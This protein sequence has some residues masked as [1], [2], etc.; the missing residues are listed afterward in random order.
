MPFK[1]R[2]PGGVVKWSGGQRPRPHRRGIKFESR[3][4]NCAPAIGTGRFYNCPVC[5]ALHAGSAS[6]CAAFFSLTSPLGLLVLHPSLRKSHVCRCLE[7]LG[8]LSP[9]QGV[10]SSSFQGLP[11]HEPLLKQLDRVSLR[12]QPRILGPLVRSHACR[13]LHLGK[14]HR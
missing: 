2:H 12:L 5:A 7:C 9:F 14:G 4:V 11:S 3:P 1:A 6:G 13:P 8:N 10:S